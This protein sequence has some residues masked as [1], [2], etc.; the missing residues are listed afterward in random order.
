VCGWTQRDVYSE[1]A[2]AKSSFGLMLIE[3]PSSAG[4]RG[5]SLPRGV[6]CYARP[7]F[8][9]KKSTFPPLEDRSRKSTRKSVL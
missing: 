4:V 3:L 7:R 1:P 8:A 5:L 9:F 2:E 6:V